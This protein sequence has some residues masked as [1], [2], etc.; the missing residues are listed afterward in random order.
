MSIPTAVSPSVLTPGLY[1]NV[2]LLAGVASPGTGLLK[3]ALLA[4]K[5]AD[6]DLTNDTEVRAGGGI[7]SAKTAFG[8]GNIGALAAE[9]IYNIFPSAQI[10]FVSPAPGSGSATVAITA[11]GAPASNNVV[12]VDIMGVTWEVTWLV[13]ETADD[14]KTKLINSILQRTASLFCT[15]ASGGSGITDITSKVA[16][17]VGNDIKVKLT[18]R[19]GTTGTETLNGGTSVSTALSGGSSDPN[20]TNALAAIAGEEYH[21]IL[22]CL[23]NTDVANVAS[24]NNLSRIKTHIDTYDSGKDCKLQQFVAGYTGTVALA[25]ASA[26]HSNSAGNSEKGELILC[27]N[28]RGLPSQLA[29]REVAGR[30]AAVSIDPAANRIGEQLNY[31]VGAYDKIADKPTAAESESAL[32][33]GVSLVSYTAQGLETL[34]RAVTT[35]SQDDAG[36]ADRR[37]LDTQNVDAAYIVARDL[38]SAMWIEFAG[39]KI[40]E[41]LEVGDD[42]LPEGVTEERDIKAFAISRLQYWTRKGVINK[43]ALDAAIEDGSLIVQVNGSDATQ[44][45]C[46][47]PFEIIQPLA[48]LGVVV[49][50]VPS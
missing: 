42:P 32:G 23:S 29:A 14:F 15:A 33:N 31:Y 16:G 35:H 50:R 12:D 37:L 45:D 7:A 5:S 24:A 48:K 40:T 9:I 4:S 41:D 6:G 17:N 19:N 44:V 18:L 28:G 34:V 20:L 13:G 25:I 22:P 47:F 3:V 43:A 39:A 1:M 26:P 36:G 46:V 11:A 38:R 49:Q 30:L 8:V 27:I 10:D 2:D 21:F